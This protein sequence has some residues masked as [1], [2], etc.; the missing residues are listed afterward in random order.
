MAMQPSPT[1]GW[2]TWTIVL[3]VVLLILVAAMAYVG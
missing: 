1:M 3:I 2:S